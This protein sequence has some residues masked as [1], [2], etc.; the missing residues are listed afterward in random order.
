MKKSIL[1]LGVAMIAGFS[2]GQV[3]VW[4]PAANGIV[5]P[6]E[7]NWTDAAN[8]TG[9]VLPAGKAVFNVANASTCILDS[10]QTLSDTL[11]IGDGGAA[12]A[13]GTLILTNGANLSVAGYFTSGWENG[14]KTVVYDG[15]SLSCASFWIGV[16][17]DADAIATNELVVKGG[18]VTIAGDLKDN[19]V[20]EYGR[21]QLDGGTV[22]AGDLLLPTGYCDI[23]GGILILQGDERVD[24]NAL[25]G[26]GHLMAF[27]GTGTVSMSYESVAD[28][29]TITGV[30]PEP[31][32]LGMV[33][34][35]GGG[36]LW[37]RKRF[38]I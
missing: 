1:C 2:M 32:T 27:G 34:L 5:P 33:S 38:A 7:G 14:G 30:I 20:G 10:T 21:I 35:I 23:T 36:I 18:T 9:G 19:N 37:I 25:I 26:S 28:E 15:A 22:T 16:I 3:N 8:W 6:A 4:N 11:V 13:A 12:G 31:A 17:S 29:T 24:M